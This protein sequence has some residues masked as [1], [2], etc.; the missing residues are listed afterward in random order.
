MDDPKVQRF[1]LYLSEMLYYYNLHD[2]D[3]SFIVFY[4]QIHLR[5]SSIF[6]LQF[7]IGLFFRRNRFVAQLV[8]KPILMTPKEVESEKP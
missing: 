1:H 3:E 4:P 8:H 6:K 7:G 5:L 2:D